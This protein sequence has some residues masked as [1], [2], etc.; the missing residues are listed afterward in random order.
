MKKFL[1]ALLIAAGLSLGVA[2][3]VA[4][5]DCALEIDGVCVLHIQM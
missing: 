3:T 2:S 1:I 5:N 4:A